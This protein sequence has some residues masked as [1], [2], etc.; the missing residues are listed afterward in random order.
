M[1]GGIFEHDLKEIGMFL[2]EVKRE[3]IVLMV[4]GRNSAHLIH[5]CLVN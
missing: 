3:L 5:F 4:L 2:E 1:S